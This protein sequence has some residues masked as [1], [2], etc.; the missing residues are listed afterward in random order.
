MQWVYLIIGGF[1]ILLLL[2]AGVPVLQAGLDQNP[3]NG[4]PAANATGDMLNVLGTAPAL[5][6]VGLLLLAVVVLL[7]GLPGVRV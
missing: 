3:A 5:L 4:S 1:V 6:V 7:L 2:T